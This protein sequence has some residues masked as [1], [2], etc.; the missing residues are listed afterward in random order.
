[1]LEFAKDKYGKIYAENTR[2]T[3]RRQAIHQFI[4]GAILLMNPDKPDRPTNSPNTTY[5][6]SD[7]ALTVIQAYDTDDFNGEA[8]AFRKEAKGGLAAMFAMAREMEKVPVTLPGGRTVEL[9][10]GDH[11]ILQAAIVQD[12]LPRFAPG[13]FVLYLGDTAH[14]SLVVEE[15]GLEELG[16]PVTEHDKLPDVVAYLEKRN[17]LFLIEAVT[18]HGPVSPKRHVEMERILADCTAERV[19][20]SAFLQ[21]KEFRTHSHDIA[22][23]SEVWIASEPDHMIHYNG[24]KFL[25]PH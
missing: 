15:D 19:Y 4:E 20:V 11:N 22:W 17:W 21:K 16:V 2:E 8:A 12:F 5:Q 9:S 13:A 3:I 7:H 25:G 1:M 10:P 24:D 18:S 23:E 6:L 14:K